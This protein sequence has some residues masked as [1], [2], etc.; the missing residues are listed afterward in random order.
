M[1]PV[2]AI[3]SS[4]GWL[5]TNQWI[6]TVM[7]AATEDV[8]EQLTMIATSACLMLTLCTVPVFAKTIGLEVIARSTYSLVSVILFVT[9]IMD[10]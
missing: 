7:A 5:A 4:V 9:Q 8:M 2:S 1:A 6:S 3:S 10:V